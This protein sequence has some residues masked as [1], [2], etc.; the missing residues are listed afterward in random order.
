MAGKLDVKGLIVDARK[1]GMSDQQIYSELQKTPQFSSITK[2]AKNELK[3]SDNQIASQF[4]L[5]L[6]KSLGVMPPITIK[7]EPEYE[8]PSFL[9]D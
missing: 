4:G 2:S 7:A 8:Q 6:P 3:M 1:M 9:A 5:N